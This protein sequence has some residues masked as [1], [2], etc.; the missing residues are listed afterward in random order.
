MITLRLAALADIS[1]IQQVAESTWP[2]SYQEIISPEQ[3]RYM[4]DLMY[5]N[6]KLE[7]AITDPNQAFWLAEEHGKVLGFCGIEHGYPEAGITRIHK[8]YILPDTQGSGLGKLFMDHVEDQAGKH[9]NNTLHLNVNK[10]NN[11]VGF[12]R[13]HGFVIDHEEVLDIGNG[14]VMDD[15]IM[16]KHLS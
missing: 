16:V 5:S 12:Y 4:L 14:Y 10:G 3:I 11:A 1:S 15:F 9:G 8:L 2:V 13:K 6:Q 7:T